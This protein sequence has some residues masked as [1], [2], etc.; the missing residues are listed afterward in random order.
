MQNGDTILGDFNFRHDTSKHDHPWHSTRHSIAYV[1]YTSR[2]RD[3]IINA[4]NAIDVC[5]LYDH[6]SQALSDSCQAIHAPH[7]SH[8]F[9]SE[10]PDQQHTPSSESGNKN[11][12]CYKVYASR[13]YVEEPYKWDNGIE[14]KIDT[15]LNLNMRKII[16]YWMKSS[17]NYYDYTVLLVWY[18]KGSTLLTEKSHGDLTVEEAPLTDCY[19]HYK[20]KFDILAF[21]HQSV[22]YSPNGVIDP[23]YRTKCV[24][25]YSKYLEACASCIIN[26]KLGI[27]KKSSAI[28]G[29]FTLSTDKAYFGGCITTMKEHACSKFE[30]IDDDVCDLDTAS[31]EK[32]ATVP[33]FYTRQ[34]FRGSS[35]SIHTSFLLIKDGASV[36]KVY[37]DS[38]ECL[39]CFVMIH[40]VKFLSTVHK[41]VWMELTTGPWSCECGIDYQKAST[42]TL[43]TLRPISADAAMEHLFGWGI[44]LTIQKG[45]FSTKRSWCSR[46]WSLCSKFD[47]FVKPL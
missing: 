29:I 16:L 37:Y 39:T 32:T 24:V 3:E 34:V 22:L 27:W 46:N 43:Q 47:S 4:C 2:G 28:S 8:H 26:N 25:A 17:A 11:L 35:T 9:A 7:K 15:F 40:S 14:Y 23:P 21:R 18:P 6:E 41:Y 38:R 20:S 44:K 12:K 42:H 1:M 36:V 33:K 45:L 13:T 31:N 19:D 30:Y 10:M 5:H